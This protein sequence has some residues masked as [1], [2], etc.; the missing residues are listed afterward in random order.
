MK[1]VIELKSDLNLGDYGDCIVDYAGTGMH[2]CDIAAE[3]ADNHVSIYYSDILKFVSEHPDSL[4]EVI[5]SGLY[6]PSDHYDFYAHA[7]AAEYM[8]IE[9]EI[10]ENMFDELQLLGIDY[11]EHTLFMNFIPDKL[12]DEIRYAADE[13]ESIDSIYDAINEWMD[14]EENAAQKAAFQIRA[15]KSP[16]KEDY[17]DLCTLADMSFEW[18]TAPDDGIEKVALIAAEKLGVE[19]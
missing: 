19:I 16:A 8:L 14:D 17:K 5:E 4:N 13:A 9:Q 1:S 3:I 15:A 10:E 18:E 11:C 6:D 2:W 12:M 7:Q